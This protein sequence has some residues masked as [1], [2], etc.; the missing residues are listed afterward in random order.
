MQLT[1]NQRYAPLTTIARIYE[2]PLATLKVR[3][4][5]ANK[6]GIAL[7]IRRRIGRQYFYDIVEFEK[8]L[9]DTANDL[10]RDYKHERRSEDE[11]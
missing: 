2:I 9:W 6:S 11:R 3:L 4:C 1:T 10:Q 5:I 8:W 7:P